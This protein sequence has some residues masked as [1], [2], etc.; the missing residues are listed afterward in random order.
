M[1][2]ESFDMDGPIDDAAEL[3]AD[4]E[5]HT[6]DAIKMQ[7]MHAR[8]EITAPV[9]VRKGNASQREDLHVRA[10]SGDLS[11]GGCMLLTP[12]PLQTGDIYYL[13]FDPREISVAPQFARCLRCRFLREDAY[14]CGF[15]F[16]KEI[17]LPAEIANSSSADPW[18]T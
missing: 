4:L 7:R 16:F 13:E 8:L 5:R 9:S 10:L 11:C 14:E 18:L 1:Y 15:Q 6:P 3:L 2:N 12:R 17:S